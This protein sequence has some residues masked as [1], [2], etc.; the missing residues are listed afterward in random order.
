MQVTSLGAAGHTGPWVLSQHFHR[1]ER[2]LGVELT[3][4]RDFAG[5]TLTSGIPSCCPK[6]RSHLLEELLSRGFTP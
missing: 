1:A 4:Q 3:L 2:R 5:Q 6:L